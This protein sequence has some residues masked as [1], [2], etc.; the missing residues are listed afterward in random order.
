MWK[1]AIAVYFWIGLLFG[2]LLGGPE[3]IKDS[4]GYLVSRA[5]FEPGNSRIQVKN[6]A[7][8]PV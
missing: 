7:S 1:E 5:R 6:V 3:E 2:H 4:L 8:E